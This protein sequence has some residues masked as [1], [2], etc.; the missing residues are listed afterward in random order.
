MTVD[1]RVSPTWGPLSL[2]FGEAVVF[3]GLRTAFP[4]V[5]QRIGDHVGMMAC[6]VVAPVG[7]V[8][9]AGREA[10][11]KGDEDYGR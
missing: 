3:P 7:V 8:D 2:S 9:A 10:A 6:R 4:L 11:Q 1:Q 5:G